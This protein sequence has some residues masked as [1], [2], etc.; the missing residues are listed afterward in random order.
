MKRNKKI[1]FDNCYIL[2]VEKKL[3]NI[4]EI[5]PY[6]E[7]AYKQQ[8]PLV[9]IAEDVESELLTTLIINKLK[10]NL[11]ICVVKAP[12]FGDNRKATMQDIAIFT[13]GQ[14]IIE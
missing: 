12:S 1:E 14:Y 5:L 13:G 9:I 2:A 11:K 6:L 7:H 10:S 3:S 8:R 4:Q